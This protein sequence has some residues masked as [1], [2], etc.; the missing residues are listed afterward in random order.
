MYTTKKEKTSKNNVILFML[1]ILIPTVLSY[2][3]NLGVILFGEEV[4]GNVI[5]YEESLESEGKSSTYIAYTPVVNIPSSE[6]VV[7]IPIFAAQDRY[8]PNHIGDQVNIKY[9]NNT[10]VIANTFYAMRSVLEMVS[11]LSFIALIP[12]S[13]L[14]FRN[15]GQRYT[16][17]MRKLVSLYILPSFL[18]AI[19]GFSSQLYLK[20]QSLY[21][22]P[23]VQNIIGGGLVI[24]AFIYSI[25]A[26]GKE[27]FKIK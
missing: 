20:N 8:M 1:I 2:G 7:N 23:S 10:V 26:L 16:L 18:T 4:K 9:I 27:C 11:M 22:E 14:I 6:E 13:T 17:K 25:V 3:K 12:L 19:L 21:F 24:S 5:R 15:F